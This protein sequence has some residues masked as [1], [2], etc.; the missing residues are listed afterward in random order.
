MELDM[1]FQG[2]TKDGGTQPLVQTKVPKAGIQYC[3]DEF[4]NQTA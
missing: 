2:C 1:S 4:I 3:G